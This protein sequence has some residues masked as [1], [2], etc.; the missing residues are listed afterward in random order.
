MQIQLH[1]IDDPMMLAIA[2][3]N[4]GIV[5]QVMAYQMVLRTTEYPP[6]S[7][8]EATFLAEHVGEMIQHMCPVEKVYVQSAEAVQEA[9]VEEEDDY[10]E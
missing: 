5:A 7:L 10:E 6:A 9:G 1:S 8:A 3:E 4:P 2:T